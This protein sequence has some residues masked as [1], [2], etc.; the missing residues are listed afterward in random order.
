MKKGVLYSSVCM[1]L[2]VYASLI[3]QK[4]NETVDFSKKEDTVCGEAQS[5]SLNAQKS[6]YTPLQKAFLYV[7]IPFFLSGLCVIFAMF[8]PVGVI[9]GI[10]LM[11][12]GGG[13]L[14]LGFR[15]GKKTFAVE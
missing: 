3:D 7:S 2:S 15:V 13:S 10:G 8:T 12:L 6:R 1:A 11:S 5:L 9:I 4:H 14:G